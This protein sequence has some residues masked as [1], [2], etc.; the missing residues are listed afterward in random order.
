MTIT[1]RDANHINAFLEPI[2]LYIQSQAGTFSQLTMNLQKQQ[3]TVTFVE[4]AEE[5]KDYNLIDTVLEKLQ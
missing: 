3:V 5:A 4:T 1:P 2:A